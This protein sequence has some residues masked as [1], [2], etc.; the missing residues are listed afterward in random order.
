MI[1]G[2]VSTFYKL[3]V[4]PWDIIAAAAILSSNKNWDITL[5]L[6]DN[7]ISSPFSNSKLY[8]SLKYVLFR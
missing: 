8:R 4:K 3:N 2:K 5:L 7:S 6:K 1:E